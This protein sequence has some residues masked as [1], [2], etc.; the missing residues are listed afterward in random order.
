MASPHPSLLDRFV[1]GVEAE[2]ALTVAPDASAPRDTVYLGGGTPSLLGV[3]RITRILHAVRQRQVLP[4]GA[5]VTLEVN[6][7]TITAA[8]LDGYVMAGVNRV[9]IGVQSFSDRDLAFLGRVHDGKR[10]EA[11]VRAAVDC[12]I[13]VSLDLIY[14]LPG[15][16]GDDVIEQLERAAS[17]GVG[18]LSAYE[19]TC[20]PGTPLAPV[21]A[22]RTNDRE[23]LFFLV[24]ERLAG[25]GL[26][27]YEVSSFARTPADR[28]MHNLAT[29][30]H[31]P[32]LGLGPAAHSFSGVAAGR[33]SRCWNL[34]D[35]DAW[36]E[37]LEHGHAP[38]RGHE[39]L[40]PEQ[41][42]LERV[43]LGLRTTLGLDLEAIRAD[44]GID[45]GDPFAARLDELAAQGL[46]TLSPGAATTTLS[47]M[48]LADRL[49]V[50]LTAHAHLNRLVEAESPRS[51]RLAPDT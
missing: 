22:A 8:E 26:T 11:A 3:S 13:R 33:A 16:S 41:L 9:S 21:L 14:G 29:W 20:E 37:S 5:E 51:S 45:L 4:P 1:H 12:G 31:Q 36:L 50:D 35:L 27:A 15:Q 49:A 40:G 24:H 32:Y 18:H 17:T 44:L 7:E 25:L 30:A 48:A 23:D 19:L 42:L 39:N 43:M 34:P 38:P 10:A 2:L 46:L 6:P 28:S 47:G